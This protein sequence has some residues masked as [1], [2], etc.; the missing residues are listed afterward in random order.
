MKEFISQLL[1]ER[2]RWA[3]VYGLESSRT[4]YNPLIVH[5]IR[6]FKRDKPTIIYSID[7]LSRH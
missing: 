3:K 2:K 4:V 6:G 5:H 7:H 1:S